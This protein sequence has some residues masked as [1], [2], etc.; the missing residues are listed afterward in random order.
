MSHWRFSGYSVMSYCSLEEAFVEKGDVWS[1]P[2]PVLP[3]SD[4]STVRM[5]KRHRKK[6]VPKGE[7]STSRTRL[8]EAVGNAADEAAT[9]DPAS[10]HSPVPEPANTDPSIYMLAPDFTRQARPASVLSGPIAESHV[11]PTDD[12][13]F[14]G[15]NHGTLLTDAWSTLSDAMKKDSFY[16]T[17][18]LAQA[19]YWDGDKGGSIGK[20][21]KQDDVLQKLFDA[22]AELA[23][24]FDQVDKARRENNNQDILLFIMIGLFIVFLLDIL[25]RRH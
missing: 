21:P 11:V 13:V 14:R 3:P 5:H 10:D 12:Q 2:G 19:P 9:T 17:Q 20:G 25:V 16:Q 18:S 22:V 4:E 7:E 24:R 6:K 1:S 15:S 8:L 23:E